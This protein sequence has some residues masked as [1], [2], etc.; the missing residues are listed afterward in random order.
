LAEY[1]VLKTEE[2]FDEAN[3][4]KE[5]TIFYYEHYTLFNEMLFQEI[6][7]KTAAAPIDICLE[8]DVF[9]GIYELVFAEE[10]IDQPALVSV[11][12]IKPGDLWM[13]VETKE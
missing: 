1:L 3:A 5:R 7:P 6:E 11:R 9:P 12:F 10:E 2:I 13:E 4:V 8:L